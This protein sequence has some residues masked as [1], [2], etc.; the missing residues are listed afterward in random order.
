MGVPWDF[1]GTS[2]PIKRHEREIAERSFAQVSDHQSLIAAGHRT[3]WFLPGHLS[4]GHRPRAPTP[5]PERSFEPV[6]QLL[7]ISSYCPVT[8]PGSTSHNDAMAR[9]T[10]GSG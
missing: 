8:S 3:R 1:S 2:G 10:G 9:G 7:A 4:G 6:A 5:L